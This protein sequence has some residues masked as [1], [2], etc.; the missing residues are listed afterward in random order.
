MR[1]SV[2]LVALFALAISTVAL[3][4][5]AWKIKV[6]DLD[7]NAPYSTNGMWGTALDSNLGGWG[8]GGG[9]F[10]AYY[11]D[12]ALG[13]GTTVCSY[14]ANTG[15]LDFGVATAQACS[16]EAWGYKAMNQVVK[17]GSVYKGW[18][19]FSSWDGHELQYATSTDGANFGLR[20]FCTIYGATDT[21]TG[22]YGFPGMSKTSSGVWFSFHRN[23]GAGY[24]NSGSVGT[25]TSG[26]G[27]T[28]WFDTDTGY[29][30]SIVSPYSFGDPFTDPHNPGGPMNDCDNEGSVA[31]ACD[32]N[33]FMIKGTFPSYWP[34]NPYPYSGTGFYA[35]NGLMMGIGTTGDLCGGDNY[36]YLADA[37]STN[38]IG[39]GNSLL[40]AIGN[41]GLSGPSLR[42]RVKDGWR[43]F[44]P[45]VLPLN[46]DR[47][48]ASSKFV[49]FYRAA[50]D[51]D[52]SSN[53]DYN[54]VLGTGRAKLFI[55]KNKADLN[56]DGTVSA[57]DIAPFSAAYNTSV[58]QPAFNADCDFNNDG[59]VNAQDIAPFSARYG[60]GCSY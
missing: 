52:S 5:D 40:S 55:T 31:K 32:G 16:W 7:P 34:G 51:T 35:G 20:T 12:G 19:R 2:L 27:T 60:A 4:S 41:P 9:F 33:L 24:Q 25:M 59:K 39:V 15:S 37:D 58:G 22:T 50:W 6:T 43:G 18:M 38:T 47:L 36:V 13:Y 23:S 28:E 17:D 53:G 26:D 11:R 14:D 57:Q 30:D 29:P 44:T 3:G 1:K 10:R 8:A 48:A 21:A 56:Y 46:A 54:D 49:M 42:A 45:N